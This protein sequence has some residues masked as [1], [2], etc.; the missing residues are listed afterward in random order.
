MLNTYLTGLDCYC[1]PVQYS[2]NHHPIFCMAQVGNYLSIYLSFNQTKRSLAW[3]HLK[4]LHPIVSCHV[5]K[6]WTECSDAKPSEFLKW[7]VNSEVREANVGERE[8]DLLCVFVCFSYRQ[9]NQ[10]ICWWPEE[11]G[12]GNN[13]GVLLDFLLLQKGM[14]IS[15]PSNLYLIRLVCLSFLN[16]RQWND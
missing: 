12:G 7:G 14:S 9:R 13:V 11:Q 8:R 4:S 10:R 15:R 1:L 5:C 16:L 2:L 3:A 6:V